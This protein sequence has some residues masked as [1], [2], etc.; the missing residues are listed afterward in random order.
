M[1]FAVGEEFEAMAQ[2]A[3]R[4]FK[5]FHP[6]VE[7]HVVEESNIDDFE[8]NDHVPK[9]IRNHYGIFRF[10]IAAEIMDKNNYDKF[11]VL[12][13]DTITCA[14]LEEFL[15]NN[16]FDLILTMDYAYQLSLPYFLTQR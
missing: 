5:K 9:V 12:G 15:G 7:L 14:R 3:I 6:D 13:A 4:S 2:C 1:I 16:S 8:A 10:A 11:I